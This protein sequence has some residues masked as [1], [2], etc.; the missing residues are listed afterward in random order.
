MTHR[1]DAR[2]VPARVE[3]CDVEGV[4]VPGQVAV[5]AEGQEKLPV[6]R[7]VVRDIG[8]H[9]H[10]HAIVATALYTFSHAVRAA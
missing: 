8:K 3:M 7:Q 2:D 9:S 1:D 4:S 10:V 5:Q 6:I